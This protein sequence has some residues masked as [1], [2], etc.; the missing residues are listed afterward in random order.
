[1][2]DT[3]STETNLGA[4]SFAVSAKGAGLESTSTTT[5]DLTPFDSN[6]TAKRAVTPV[7]WPFVFVRFPS[8][9]RE[10][11]LGQGPER[12]NQHLSEF[13]DTATKSRCAVPCRTVHLWTT[14]RPP[15]L[16]LNEKQIPRFVGNNGNASRKWNAWNELSCAQGRRATRL[17]YAP[18]EQLIN[19]TAY[20]RF[21]ATGM[22]VVERKIASG[23]K[24]L[25]LRGG[26]LS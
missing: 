4:A 2:A 21:G 12:P 9:A 23:R 13:P 8:P 26:D 19:S 22:G 16:A 18:T 14:L 7:F 1:V 20:L 6:W 25:C 3:L 17:R 24:K 10:I 11:V 5:I 15:G